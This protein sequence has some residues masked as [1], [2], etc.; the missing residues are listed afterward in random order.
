MDVIKV[1]R[2]QDTGNIKSPKDLI[3]EMKDFRSFNEAMFASINN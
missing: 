1:G 3:E 2:T